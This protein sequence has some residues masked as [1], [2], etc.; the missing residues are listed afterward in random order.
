MASPHW[1]EHRGRYWLDAA[2]YADTHGIHFDNYREMWSYRDW[3]IDAFN[4]NQRFD[5]FTVEQLAGDLLPNRTLDQQIASGFNRCNMTTNEGGAINEEYLVLYAR[6]RTETTSLVWMG[7]TTGCA[8]C[9]DHKFDPVSQ[10]EFYSLAAF[11]NNT[12]QNAM[13]GNVHNTPPTVMVTRPED[14]AKGEAVTAKLELARKALE[15]RKKVARKDFDLWAKTAKPDQFADKVPTQGRV[16]HMP[17]SEGQGAK[18]AGQDHGKPFEVALKNNVN[19]EAGPRGDKAFYSDPDQT[20]TLP[21]AGNFGKGQAFTVSTWVQDQPPGRERGGPG[22]HE[23]RRQQLPRLGLVARGRP[24]RHA[25]HP[26][27]A[28]RCPQGRHQVGGRG[29]EVVPRHRLLRRLGQGRRHQD[30]LRRHPPDG[31]GDERQPQ[32]R[33]PHHRPPQ[34]RH[35]RPGPAPHTR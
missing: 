16:L 29:P 1:G 28:D 10:K 26:R 30:L 13:D 8:V 11:F 32:G 23:R 4:K 18:L 31:R 7:L 19:W 3:V 20:L 33:H 21:E 25:R 27:L 5:Q 2:R 35:P 12:T 17:L 34:A 14:R 9:H 24:D 22:A 6:D 15:E